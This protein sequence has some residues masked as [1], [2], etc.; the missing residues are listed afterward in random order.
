MSPLGDLT[1]RRDDKGDQ[2]S[3]GETTWTNTGATRY[4]RGQ[5]KTGQFGDGCLMMMMMMMTRKRDIPRDRWLDYIMAITKCT[6]AE[7][8]SLA[9]ERNVWNKEIMIITNRRTLLDGTT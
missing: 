4:G 8:C 3:G 2:P 9:I 5:H 7:L 6:L 1:T